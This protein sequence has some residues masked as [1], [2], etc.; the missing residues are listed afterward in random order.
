MPQDV[1]LR[2]QRKH[3]TPPWTPV[4]FTNV[5]PGKRTLQFY[6]HYKK[7]LWRYVWQRR[8]NV[9]FFLSI[10]FPNKRSL[11]YYNK[12]LFYIS[13]YGHFWQSWFLISATRTLGITICWVGGSQTKRQW[14]YF[15]A[16]Q[17]YFRT[18]FSC[19]KVI[20]GMILFHLN[21][22]DEALSFTFHT[23]G[24]ISLSFLLRQ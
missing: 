12:M 24:L 3:P 11:Y 10:L 5:A 8:L 6:H 22:R 7:H 15:C 2:C 18:F 21:S 23:V 17:F 9:I 13:K 1:N 16:N 14:K 19:F 4:S 20:H